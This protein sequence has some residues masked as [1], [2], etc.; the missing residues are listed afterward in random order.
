MRAAFDTAWKHAIAP[1]VAHIAGVGGMAGPLIALGASEVKTAIDKFL[2]AKDAKAA[3]G[4]G[5]GVPGPGGGA[6]AANAALARK[7][8][9]AWGSG[10][11][12]AAWNAVEMREAGWNQYARNA[13]SGA[14]GIP[15]ALPP[16][17]MGAAANPPESNVHAQ[18]S[19][20]ISYIKGRYGDPIGALA[21]ENAY[22]WYAKGTKGAAPG[23]AWVGEAGP[24]LVKMHG[25]ETVIPHAASMAIG[26]GIGRG[27]AAG[28][29]DPEIPHKPILAAIKAERE[30]RWTLTQAIRDINLILRG[31]IS[32]DLRH[33]LIGE[34]HQDERKRRRVDHELD[35]LRHD[36][37]R[38]RKDIR[39][40]N[41]REHSQQVLIG[42]LRRQL[43][44][45]PPE[46]A[47]R[48]L[49]LINVHTWRL[50]NMRSQ[51]RVDEWALH[52]QPHSKAPA[53][54]ALIALAKELL[55]GS[56]PKTPIN[57]QI[58]ANLAIFNRDQRLLKLPGLSK[59]DHDI[60]K[61]ER[62]AAAKKLK[63]FRK[64]AKELRAY[65]DVLG[66]DE[67]VVKGE[68]ADAERAHDKGD[69]TKFKGQLSRDESLVSTINLWL[70]G[71]AKAGGGGS[72][73]GSGGG[74]SG[75]GGG[76]P[77]TAPAGRFVGMLPAGPGAAGGGDFTGGG[78]GGL[79]GSG[80]E[81]LGIPGA[82]GG[83]ALRAAQAR[84]RAVPAAARLRVPR[85]GGSS[86]PAAP[87]A[88][89]APLRAAFSAGAARISPS[90]SSQAPPAA[91][92]W[93]SCWTGSIP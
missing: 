66:A 72:G 33:H 53:G 86:P 19:W 41:R 18:I 91:A 42:S 77:G 6:P 40:L 52:G 15:Q 23:W 16:S 60:L 84:P 4:G 62:D 57:D 69:I 31:N 21:H 67:V 12:W 71:K 26:G 56:T 83:R 34:V 35:S 28:T 50:K 22:G 93:A 48:L 45:A 81:L 88:P 76:G 59:K 10:A 63:F 65:R 54:P 29:G 68:L 27:Y 87:L 20:M 5:A 51:E 8:Y 3:G 64:E 11:E 30:K 75:G 61:K 82:A 90:L 43:A 17:K 2:G 46:E 73:D 24:E 55:K 78:T 89:L 9:P 92:G 14:Y 7:M 79:G 49:D 25:G 37:D 44:G 38:V 74:D 47:A 39:Q 70:R 58:A 1:T 85:R 80:A 32:R 13:S 36:R